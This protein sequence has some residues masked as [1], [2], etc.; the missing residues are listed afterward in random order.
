MWA[1]NS[2]TPSLKPDLNQQRDISLY[3]SDALHPTTNNNCT[4]LFKAY[5]KD[6]GLRIPPRGK[7]SS[8]FPPCTMDKWKIYSNSADDAYHWS[9][10]L[11]T[12]ITVFGT[13]RASAIQGTQIHAVTVFKKWRLSSTSIPPALRFP[14][15]DSLLQANTTFRSPYVPL[16]GPW[17]TS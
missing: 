4:P 10:K 9:S 7:Q 2:L 8:F 17:T 3:I 15:P 13:I 1:T 11:C 14:P 12:A 16:I 5:G 6:D